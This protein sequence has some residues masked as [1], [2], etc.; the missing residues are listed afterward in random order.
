LQLSDTSPQSWTLYFAPDQTYNYSLRSIRDPSVNLSL[1]NKSP[2]GGTSDPPAVWVDDPDNVF[3]LGPFVVPGSRGGDGGG[4]RSP[5]APQDGGGGSRDGGT[6]SGASGLP[7]G[8]LVPVDPNAPD[9]NCVHGDTGWY[10]M[11]I[12]SNGYT[13]PADNVTWSHI[14]WKLDENGNQARLIVESASTATLIGTTKTTGANAGTVRAEK[15]FKKCTDCNNPIHTTEIKPELKLVCEKELSPFEYKSIWPVVSVTNYNAA[16]MEGKYKM[17]FYLARKVIEEPVSNPVKEVVQNLHDFRVLGGKGG[18]PMWNVDRVTYK[19]HKAFDGTTNKNHAASLGTDFFPASNTER[20]R[21]HAITEFTPPGHYEVIAEVFKTADNSFVT[22][23]R[24]PVV[25]P[26]MVKMYCGTSTFG[27][28]FLDKR[29]DWKPLF[30]EMKIKYTRA[31]AENIQEEV[32][33][34]IPKIF[35]SEFGG[36]SPNIRFKREPDPWDPEEPGKV[37]H[38]SIGFAMGLRKGVAALGEAE[39]VQYN[40]RPG[41]SQGVVYLAEIL[42]ACRAWH[43]FVKENKDDPAYEHLKLDFLNK[44]NLINII[45]FV[46]AHEIGHTLGLV[47]P[48]TPN[49]YS[50]DSG[51][52]SYDEEITP[53]SVP[54]SF[55]LYIMNDG[56]KTSPAVRAGHYGTRVWS[57]YDKDY[58]EFILPPLP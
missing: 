19:E 24:S 25:V 20:R 15:T 48:T 56:D 42:S 27:L 9:P 1:S 49:I 28:E 52:Y 4:A 44:E 14:D 32:L 34:R 31:E 11:E 12:T 3:G 51:H 26:Q 41:N 30:A 22:R 46:A 7:T 17:T 21:L 38:K 33:K 47:S 2:S 16:A 39:N 35:Q 29:N 8:K 43:K 45:A 36:V 37:H 57:P 23:A 53:N 58:L 5:S 18:P 55:K 54:S 10:T 13:Y 40:E 50:V 6:G